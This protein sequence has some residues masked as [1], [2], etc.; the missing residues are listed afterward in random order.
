MKVAINA[1]F[2]DRPSVGSGQYLHHLVPA[3]LEVDSTLEITLVVPERKLVHEAPHLLKLASV[4]PVRVRVG[5]LG[6]VWFEQRLFPRACRQVGA[7]LAHVPYFGSPLAPPLPTVVT[8]H[9][10]IPMVLPEYRG[11][12][13][14]RLYTSLVAAAAGQAD[15]ILTDSQASSRDILARLHLPPERVRVVYLA[16]A[17]QFEPV[18]DWEALD[19]VKEKYGLPENFILYMGGFDARKNV[20]ALLHAWTWV[21]RALGDEYPLVLAGQL[22]DG[23]SPL[24]PDPLPV[25]RALG[26]DDLVIT[27]GWIEEADKPAL[28]SAAQVFVYPSRYEGFGLPVLEAMACGTPVVTTTAASLPELTG[29]HAFQIDPDD[30]KHLASPI[31]ALTVQEDTHQEMSERGLWQASQFTWEKAAQQTLQAYQDVMV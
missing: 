18:V 14:V 27:P 15:L 31:I 16:P 3:L 11:G 29:P 19:A 26:I 20:A 13:S 4:H 1:W 23:D 2:W 12:L 7:D 6:K 25:A 8:I 24:F 30:T 9:D 28:Y 17:P 10:L 21:A 5:N 22:P